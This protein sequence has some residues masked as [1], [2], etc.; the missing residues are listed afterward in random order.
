MSADTDIIRSASSKWLRDNEDKAR[1]AI[2]LNAKFGKAPEPVL[3]GLFGWSDYQV[4]D[5]LTYLAMIEGE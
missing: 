3:K 4:N 1:A 5:M 2:H